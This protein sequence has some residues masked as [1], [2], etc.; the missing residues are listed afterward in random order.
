M[1]KVWNTAI[2]RYSP[3]G[4]RHRLVRVLDVSL[5]LSLK[6]PRKG[7]NAKMNRSNRAAFA[8]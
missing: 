5:V 8:K 6:L 3:K 4:D 1:N 7:T 2:R